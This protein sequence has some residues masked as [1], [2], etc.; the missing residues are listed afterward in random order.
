MD[1]T[2]YEQRSLVIFRLKYGQNDPQD[3]NAV[4][5]NAHSFSFSSTLGKLPEGQKNEMLDGLIGF[6]VG[7]RD[8]VVSYSGKHVVFAKFASDCYEP[9]AEQK[10]Y[11]MKIEGERKARDTAQN[12]QAFWARVGTLY[13][14]QWEHSWTQ[15]DNGSD[16]TF[17]EAKKYCEN[18][19]PVTQHHGIWR[20]P[21]SGIGFRG[22]GSPNTVGFLGELSITIFKSDMSKPCN[23]GQ[24]RLGSCR[25][26]AFD[27]IRKKPVLIDLEHYQRFEDGELSSRARDGGIPPDSKAHV[28]C[29]LQE[30][31]W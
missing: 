17:E 23:L 22:D 29:V 31:S 5:I 3:L 18:L 2:D 20:L 25:L 12:A 4:P 28:L 15:S 30:G 7:G 10:A 14:A 26:W 24:F 16:V 19:P 1:N 9:S 27:D 11:L 21:R 13:D 6:S 8:V